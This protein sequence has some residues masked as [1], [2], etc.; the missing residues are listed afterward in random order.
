MLDHV[1]SVSQWL[2]RDPD[3]PLERPTPDAFRASITYCLVSLDPKE[4]QDLLDE[5]RA[6]AFAL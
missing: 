6:S 5:L 3:N 4:P 2:V 1:E